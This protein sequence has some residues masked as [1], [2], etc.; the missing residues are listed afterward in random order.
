MLTQSSQA[1][2]AADRVAPWGDLAFLHQLGAQGSLKPRKRPIQARSAATVHAIF[3]ASIQVLLSVGY[4]KLTTSRVAERAGVSVGTLYQ[5]FPN[6]QSLM[7]AV[8]ERYL[9]EMSASIEAD[10]QSLKERSLDETAA[11][12]VDAFIAAKWRR[13]EVS[14]AMHEP[15]SEV[16]GVELVRAAAVKGAAIAAKALRGCREIGRDDVEPLAVF[17]V[18]A[19]TSI[20][21]ERWTQRLS[22]SLVVT[23]AL[24]DERGAMEPGRA[25]S[26]LSLIRL[27]V[28]RATRTV[29]SAQSVI[30]VIAES[31]VVTIASCLHG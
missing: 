2:V 28:P 8:L 3:E 26:Q 18:M 20:A 13:L 22:M 24:P 1:R 9:A 10:C 5:Y 6:R 17:L 12:L 14:R 29:N 25:A 19:C 31:S 7:R 11:G 30:A 16:G 21:N 4:R 15:L 23:R 27:V